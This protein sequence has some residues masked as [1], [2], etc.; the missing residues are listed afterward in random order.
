M[1]ISDIHFDKCEPENQGLIINAFFKDLNSL[2]VDKPKDDIYCIISGDLVQAGNSSNIY[3]SF[4]NKFIKRLMKIISVKNIICTPGNHDLNRNII[5]NN[6]EEYQ[7]LVNKDY[8]EVEFNNLVKED[9]SLISQKFY[10]YRNFCEDRLSIPSFN[11]YGYSVNLIPEISCFCL[12][13]A[14]LSYGGL[15]KINDERILKIETSELNKWLDENDGRKKILIL[16]H[17]FEHLSEYAQKELNSMLRSGI[18]IIISGHIHDQNLENSYISQEAK[19]IKCSSPQ[20]FSDKTDLNGYSIL[21]FEDSNLLKI[22]Y[23]QWSKRQRKFMSGQEF[24]GTEN[25]IFEFK[26]VGYSKDDFILEKLKLEFLRA[27]KTYGTVA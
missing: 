3:D 13:S 14:L 4:Y 21:H 7:K 2:L 10:Y 16:H 6:F 24:S 15:N 11:I 18:D 12:N 27:M 20:L 8:S 22:E 17:P 1:H 19:Y 9:K 26:K 25:G 23:R 5:E